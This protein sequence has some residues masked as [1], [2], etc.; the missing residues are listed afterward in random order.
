MYVDFSLLITEA[1][2]TLLAEDDRPLA[3]TEFVV[4]LADVGPGDDRQRREK[5]KKRDESFEQYK[6]EQ[7]ALR[8]LIEQA[9][10]PI[11]EKEVTVVDDGEKVEILLDSRPPIVMPSLP[12]FDAQDVVREVMSVLQDMQIQAKHMAIAQ[13]RVAKIMRRRRDDEFLL[14]MS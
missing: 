3:I 7:K 4:N 10:E 12:Q 14:L 6:Q 9:V 13:A 5:Q 2:G 1:G 11:K 8:D